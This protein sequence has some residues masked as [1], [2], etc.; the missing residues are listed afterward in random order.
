MTGRRDKTKNVLLMKVRVVAL[1]EFGGVDS[2]ICS[3]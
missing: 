3:F 2:R 1:G